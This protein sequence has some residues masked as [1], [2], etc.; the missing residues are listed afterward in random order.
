MFHKFSCRK[1]CEIV[2]VKRSVLQITRVIIVVMHFKKAMNFAVF[3]VI[4]DVFAEGSD[5][6]LRGYIELFRRMIYGTICYFYIV[7]DKGFH[8]LFVI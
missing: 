4:K 2:P 5:S 1:W 8:I 3:Y 7:I 6:I